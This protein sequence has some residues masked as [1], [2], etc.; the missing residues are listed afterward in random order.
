M[1]AVTTATANGVDDLT[2]RGDG[3]VMLLENI[4]GTPPALSSARTWNPLARPAR[5]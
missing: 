4:L 1:P 3:V 2:D 5:G